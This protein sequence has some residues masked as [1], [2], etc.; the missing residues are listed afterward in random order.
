MTEI[1]EKLRKIYA[2]SVHGATE[3][4][5]AAASARLA[6]LLIK[7]DMVLA[8][9]LDEEKELVWFKYKTTMQ[10]RL[11]AQIAGKVAND[12]KLP[13]YTSGSRRNQLAF[14]L[15]RVHAVEIRYLFDCYDKALSEEIEMTYT[16]F[17]Y[18][19]RIFAR[20]TPEEIEKRRAEVTVEDREELTK[21]EQRMA[22]IDHVAVRKALMEGGQG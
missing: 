15:T 9:I 2:L 10:R 16:A 1:K 5:R 4:E 13:G 6:E 20:L 8:D 12:A 22:S 11:L 14:E 7:H 17:V 21:I 19:Q 18:R 3:G